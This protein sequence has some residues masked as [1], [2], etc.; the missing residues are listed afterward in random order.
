MDLGFIQANIY[1]W[2]LQV[3]MMPTHV[4][5]PPVGKSVVIYVL[6]I[7]NSYID[8]WWFSS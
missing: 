7:Y 2:Y 1:H 5:K 8:S 4:F 3:L 6:C